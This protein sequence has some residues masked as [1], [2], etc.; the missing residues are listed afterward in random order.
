MAV[1]DYCDL[2]SV[3]LKDTR[4]DNYFH[5]TLGIQLNVSNCF[6]GICVK[7]ESVTRLGFPTYTRVE[8]NL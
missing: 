4:R 2:N 1:K 8:E 5:T 6:S 7:I 3:S